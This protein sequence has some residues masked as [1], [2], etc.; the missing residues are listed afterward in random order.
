MRFCLGNLS[1]LPRP[2][3]FIL[4]E[5]FSALDEEQLKRHELTGQTESFRFVKWEEFSEELLSFPIDKIAAKEFKKKKNYQ[6]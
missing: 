5:S 2:D 6:P 1:S 3:I 4:D